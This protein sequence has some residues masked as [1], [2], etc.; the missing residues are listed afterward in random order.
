MASYQ[1]SHAKVA[2][3]AG[4]SREERWNAGG[5]LDATDALNEG[6]MSTEGTGGATLK[7]G[8]ALATLIAEGGFVGHQT[9]TIRVDRRRRVAWPMAFLV[10]L[11]ISPVQKASIMSHRSAMRPFL[12]RGASCLSWLT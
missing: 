11:F 2:S 1:V 4:M 6:G 7:S 12:M 9:Y 10:P 3:L 8:L 5:V